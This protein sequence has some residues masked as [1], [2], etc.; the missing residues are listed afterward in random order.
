MNPPEYEVSGTGCTEVCR[1]GRLKL[2]DQFIGMT[3]GPGE[4]QWWLNWTGG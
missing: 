2:G 3:A 4:R 1:G